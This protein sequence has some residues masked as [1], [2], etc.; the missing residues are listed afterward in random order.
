MSE[1]R[2][3]LAHRADAER[4]FTIVEVLIVAAIVAVLLIGVV[5]W[6]TPSGARPV[7]KPILAGLPSGTQKVDV[8]GSF[9]RVPTL[10]GNTNFR[11]D[12]RLVAYPSGTTITTIPATLPANVVPLPN[13]PVTFTLGGPARLGAGVGAGALT[14]TT[15]AQGVATLSIIAAARSPPPA[16]VTATAT[17]GGKT[18]TEI[19]TITEVDP[20]TAS[21]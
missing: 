8:Y 4:G 5:W 3:S 16:T 14:A 9:V 7:L 1:T 15:N 21:Q 19:A 11:V 20:S 12:F 17:I 6:L 13:I 2:L 18:G 10:L